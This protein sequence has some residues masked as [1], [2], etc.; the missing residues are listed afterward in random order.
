M[1][2]REEAYS[3]THARPFPASALMKLHSVVRVSNWARRVSSK[4]SF[5]TGSTIVAQ[6][7]SWGGEEEVELVSWEMG[8]PP[9][10][11]SSSGSCIKDSSWARDSVC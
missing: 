7:S 10:E 5:V 4:V 3:S 9:S 2:R 11:L 1:L 8:T 6:R